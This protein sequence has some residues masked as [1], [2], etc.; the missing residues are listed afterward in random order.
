MRLRS[1]LLLVALLVAAAAAY[2]LLW[3]VPIQPAVWTA[4]AAPGYSGPHQV[5]ERLAALKQIRI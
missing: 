2:L 1:V 3:P 5:N 4:P